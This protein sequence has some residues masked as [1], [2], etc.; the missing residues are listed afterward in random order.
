[1]VFITTLGMFYANVAYERANDIRISNVLV[2]R[3]PW[4]TPLPN[5]PAQSS[6][7]SVMTPMPTNPIAKSHL[8]IYSNGC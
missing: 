4:T 5:A 6:L 1:M 7:I 3:Y 8:F 2:M